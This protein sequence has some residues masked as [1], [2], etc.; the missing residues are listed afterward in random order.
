MAHQAI[1]SVTTKTSTGPTLAPPPPPQCISLFLLGGCSVT[2]HPTER[3]PAWRMRRD[4]SPSYF[5]PWQRRRAEVLGSASS[6][7]VF[8]WTKWRRSPR[9]TK[10]SRLPLVMYFLCRPACQ[11]SIFP[12]FCLVLWFLL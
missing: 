10:V 5:S 6:V 1:F 12:G 2:C 9:L 11:E 4:Y 7:C 3:A 8:E